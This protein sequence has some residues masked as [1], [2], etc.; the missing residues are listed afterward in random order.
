MNLSKLELFTNKH[1]ETFIDAGYKRTAG[2][3]LQYA[4][5]IGYEPA[6]MEQHKFKRT[7]NRFLAVVSK[8]DANE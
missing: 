6:V 4:L 8:R 2:G 5:S 3:V 1:I 7:A